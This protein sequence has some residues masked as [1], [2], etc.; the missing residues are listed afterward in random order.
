MK[1]LLLGYNAN[2]KPI[3]LKPEDARCHTH[4]IGASGS[5]KSKFL[6]HRMREYL[7]RGQGFTFVDPHGQTYDDIVAYAAHHA[8]DRNLILLNLSK[9][10]GGIIAFNPFR[11]APNGDVSV[12]VDRRVTAV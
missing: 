8:L 11:R 5:G 10:D 4:V 12:Q 2:E 7:K 1:P 3:H 9:P 6:E